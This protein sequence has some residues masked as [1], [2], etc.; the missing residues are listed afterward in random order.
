M[1]RN[2]WFRSRRARGFV[3]ERRW[4]GTGSEMLPHV[5]VYDRRWMIEQS[6][7]I[8][9]VTFASTK[10]ALRT[11]GTC[12]GGTLGLNVQRSAASWTNKS[13]CVV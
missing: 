13:V 3:F 8:L 5:G 2:P 11:L 6:T 12:A 1:G 4:H 10:L 7:F 9:V